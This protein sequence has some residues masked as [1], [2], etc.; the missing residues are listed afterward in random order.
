M[1]GF[2]FNEQRVAGNSKEKVCHQLN[3]PCSHWLA[4]EA[5]LPTNQL[6]TRTNTP[7][8]NWGIG[9]PGAGP[10]TDHNEFLLTEKDGS[11]ICI[12]NS[13]CESTVVRIRV[14][15]GAH[16]AGFY[17]PVHGCDKFD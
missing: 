9:H 11:N 8:G 2:A 7:L 10:K 16:A 4:P 14:C 12:H 3:S 6:L 1:H 13:V 17:S 5:Y 15:I